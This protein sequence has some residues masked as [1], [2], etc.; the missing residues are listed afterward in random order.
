MKKIKFINLSFIEENLSKDLSF[1]RF[2]IQNL[3]PSYG[4]TIGN[5][6]RRV[7]L[8]SLPGAGIVYVEIKGV[9]HEFS[10]ITGVYEDVMSIVLNLKQ[11]V[12]SVDSIDDD[13]EQKMELF[14]S[15][16][17]KVT[18]SCFEQV[19]GVKIINPEQEIAN[20][21]SED[22]SLKMTVLI[23]RGIGYVS[24]EENKIYTKK[25]IGLIS[26]DT[27]YTP[28]SKVSYD[29]EKKLGDKEE[30]A[31]EITT[32]KSITAKSALTMA[33]KILLD[34]FSFLA[35]LNEK[36]DQ[37]SFIYEPKKEFPNKSLE[38]RIDQLELSVRLYNC[39][40]KSGIEKVSDLVLLKEEEVSRLKS[41][42]RKSFDELKEKFKQHGLEFQNDL[43]KK[44]YYDDE[45]EIE[46]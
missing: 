45:E 3:E 11:V 7:L 21:V 10:T 28:V 34:H 41:L 37:I 46:E 35:N 20:L 16:K 36:K 6:L 23:K 8:S 4:V 12:I 29:I 32:N 27:L 40:K 30:L 44:L 13:F 1:G 33:S 14:V 22:A 31:I 17:K 2:I 26:I 19:E 24:A 42:G 15:G 38:L 39:L 5:P 25:K 43:E 18:A 9:D